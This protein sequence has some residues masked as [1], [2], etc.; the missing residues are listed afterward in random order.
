MGV[1]CVIAF[2]I[3]KVPYAPLMGTLIGFFN[4][5]PYFGPIIGSVPVILVSF[6]IDPP[7]ALTA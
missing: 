5:I 6:F 1:I 3:A 2:T 7:K 4:I